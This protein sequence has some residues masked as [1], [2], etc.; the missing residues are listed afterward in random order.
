[1]PN[2][3][4]DTIDALRMDKDVSALERIVAA[5]ARRRTPSLNTDEVATVVDDVLFAVVGQIAKFVPTITIAKQLWR[6]T[7][8]KISDLQR[9]KMRERKAIDATDVA[10]LATAMETPDVA[11]IMDEEND[12]DELLSDFEAIRTQNPDY[13]EALIAIIDGVPVGQRIR[14]RRGRTISRAMERQLKSRAKQKLASLMS[15]RKKE[16][17]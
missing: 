6:I 15:R 14:E 7:T 5:F 13:F 1:M 2:G 4:E 3:V 10:G 9:Y 12:L 17:S 16:V 11:D 8:N